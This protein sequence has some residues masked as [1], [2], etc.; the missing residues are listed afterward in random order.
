MILQLPNVIGP[1]VI[2]NLFEIVFAG[3][4]VSGLKTAVGSAAQVKSNEQ[5][6]TTS[7]RAQE[8]GQLLLKT[9]RANPIFEAATLPARIV[10]PRFSRYRP[11]MRYGDH[12]DA[13]LMGDV[14]PLR[15][16]MAV[17]VFLAERSSYDGGEL[18]ID[19]DHGIQRIK[20]DI[21][22]CVIYPA[23][24]LH[25]V[26]EVTRGERIVGFF[27]IQSLVRDPAQRKILFDLSGIT[28]YLDHTSQPGGHIETLRR[29][30]ANLIRM[31]ANA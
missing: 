13:P 16:D 15:T 27:W 18:V 17:T 20:G 5:L 24:T 23:N 25:R 6:D 10:P 30:N 9:M 11:G 19:T 8:A 7:D 26:E 14:L 21:G 22:S 3:E 29:C 1:K 2:E 4:F 31:W 12:L 28:Q